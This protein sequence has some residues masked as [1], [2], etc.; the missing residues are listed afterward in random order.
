[1]ESS[2]FP[3]VLSSVSG[4]AIFIVSNRP[5]LSHQL[6]RNVYISFSTTPNIKRYRKYAITAFF[7]FF[8]IR[9]TEIEHVIEV[10]KVK[11]R[12]IRQIS[13]IGERMTIT[14]VGIRCK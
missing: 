3:D 13:A 5:N 9:I 8:S 2:V 1:M 14:A 11:N 10:I 6:S 7:P 12:P 4:K